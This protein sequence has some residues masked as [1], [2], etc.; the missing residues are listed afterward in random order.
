M[1]WQGPGEA[2]DGMRIA[3]PMLPVIIGSRFER[4]SGVLYG[5]QLKAPAEASLAVLLDALAPGAELAIDDPDVDDGALEVRRATDGFEL[6]RGR[7]GC[8]GE[9]RPG[10]HVEAVAWLWPGLRDRPTR[11]VALWVPRR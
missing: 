9:W 4:G 11:V 1:T 8:A 3:L 2:D 5:L 7:H 6:K 10:S